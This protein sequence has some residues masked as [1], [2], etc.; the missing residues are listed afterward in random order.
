MGNTSISIRRPCYSEARNF[1]LYSIGE[2]KFSCTSIGNLDVTA[3]DFDGWA[4]A[5]GSVYNIDSF[6]DYN[7][8]VLKQCFP[9]YPNVDGHTDEH[10]DSTRIQVPDL[11]G[12]FFRPTIEG[13]NQDSRGLSVVPAQV[14]IP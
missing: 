1:Y 2:I 7:R 11:Q 3:L 10:P 6:A 8:D 5:D 13:L 9:Y 14:G 12:K 4:K